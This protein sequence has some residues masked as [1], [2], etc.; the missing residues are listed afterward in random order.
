MN[1]PQLRFCTRCKKLKSLTDFHKHQR[2]KN[3]GYVQVWCKQ[4]R[5]E[6]SKNTYPT[7][8]EK[9]REN[10]T[11]RR[12]EIRIG[13]IKILGSKCVYCGD[14]NLLHLQIDHINNDGNIER[15][16]SEQT[17][18]SSKVALLYLKGI[19]DINKLQILCANC[20]YEKQMKRN[21]NVIKFY[22]EVM[23]VT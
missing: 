6:H 1:E 11:R 9:I 20:N 23:K 13:I 5:S 18:M 12:F 14:S 10:T 19:K 16:E 21:K 7:R 22:E 15:K 8:K 2:L 17:G 3:L 4:C